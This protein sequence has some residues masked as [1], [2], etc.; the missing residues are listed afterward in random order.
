[1]FAQQPA[2]QVSSCLTFWLFSSTLSLGL[3][4]SQGCQKCPAD[5]AGLPDQTTAQP[6]AIRSGGDPQNR[7][8]QEVLELGTLHGCM[9][10]DLAASDG[11]AVT[12][13]HE[14][15]PPGQ[16]EGG[17]QQCTT[18]MAV[19]ADTV[20]SSQVKV[21]QQVHHTSQQMQLWRSSG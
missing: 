21:K 5:P 14:Q 16:F 7:T 2:F 12:G 18:R 9:R 11:A 15:E 6:E 1:M 17:R 20:Q 13:G 4:G 10:T 19:D 8:Q 3:A